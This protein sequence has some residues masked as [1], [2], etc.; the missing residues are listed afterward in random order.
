MTVM[1]VA[2]NVVVMA[3]GAAEEVAVAL[4]THS[5]EVNVTA[6]AAAALSTAKVA[7]VVAAEAATAATVA[8]AAAAE[9]TAATDEAVAEAATVVAE[10]ATVA[11]AVETVLVASAT[12]SRKA[13]VTVGALADSATSKL[14]GF[15]LFSDRVLR[16]SIIS[17]VLAE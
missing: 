1:A 2:G 17:F 6:E 10:A 13:N 9:A 4:A 15:S 3:T 5:R 14:Y 12:P 8:A 16:S 7:A 11:V